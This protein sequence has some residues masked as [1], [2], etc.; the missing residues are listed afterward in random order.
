L[1]TSISHHELRH[2][3]VMNAESHRDDVVSALDLL[4]MGI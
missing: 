3:P 4:V 1:L 2:E